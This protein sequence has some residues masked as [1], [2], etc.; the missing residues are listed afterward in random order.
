MAV[1]PA[2][3]SPIASPVGDADGGEH[4]GTG[5]ELVAATA[6]ITTAVQVGVPP[7]L[8]TTRTPEPAGE[9]VLEPI[10]QIGGVSAGVALSGTVA[11]LGVGPRVVAVDVSQAAQPKQLGETPPLSGVVWQIRWVGSTA[12]VAG[13]EGTTV[14]DVSD[15]GHPG[16]VGVVLPSGRIDVRSG[17]L[18]I[19]NEPLFGGTGVPTEHGLWLVDVSDP[20]RPRIVSRMNLP[21]PSTL[22]YDSV[23]EDV[24]L[25]GY[26]A[27]V[28]IRDGTVRVV[29]VRRPDA[30]REVA[31]L[32]TGK[33][34][35]GPDTYSAGW[36]GKIEGH[37]LYMMSPGRQPRVIDISRPETPTLVPDQSAGLPCG[38]VWLDHRLAYAF[39]H[40]SR[41][42]VDDIFYLRTYSDTAAGSEPSR[43]M[44]SD[45][46]E[47][48]GMPRD[49]A[50]AGDKLLLAAGDDGLRLVDVSGPLGAANWPTPA[51]GRSVIHEVGHFDPAWSAEDIVLDGSIGYVGTGL[52][53][54]LSL[55]LTDPA[56]PTVIG[57]TAVPTDTHKARVAKVASDGRYLYAACDWHNGRSEGWQT[58]GPFPNFYSFHVMD[59]RDPRHLMELGRFDQTDQHCGGS[60]A[61]GP[62]DM[63]GLTLLPGQAFV[64]A[65]R[66]GVQGFDVRDPHHPTPIDVSE[67]M[68]SGIYYYGLAAEHG[69]LYVTSD[70]GNSIIDQRNPQRSERVGDFATE[71]PC[72]GQV[73]P[74]CVETMAADAGQLVVGSGPGGLRIY[75]LSAPQKPRLLGAYN[76]PGKYIQLETVGDGLAIVAEEDIADQSGATWRI[77]DVADPAAM[78]DVGSAPVGSEGRLAHGVLYW[79]DGLNGL[80][81]LRVSRPGAP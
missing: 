44:E 70:G 36:K 69:H 64:L 12:F 11:L 65:G 62:F 27:F 59:A 13:S 39:V 24:V 6:T 67:G 43:W 76:P 37:M 51:P 58:D 4:S 25:N 28:L 19:V 63:A 78:R 45:D 53:S 16:P 80:R 21:A 3:P 5:A 75:D 81:V 30:P 41:N 32:P 22:Y 29:D 66:G 46:F 1:T 31:A 60:N 17:L 68:H 20:A 54:V 49:F 77:I 48:A 72:D 55:D 73:D 14:L 2:L 38:T 18:A 33:R 23:P 9:V 52:P 79:P 50:V 71:V 10:A 57:E 15:A 74:F 8:R 40:V 47:L 34:I 35:C 56:N 26:Y 7:E 42:I 61:C